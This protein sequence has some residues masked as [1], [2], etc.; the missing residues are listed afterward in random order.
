MKHMATSTGVLV[1]WEGLVL[2]ACEQRLRKLDIG[3]E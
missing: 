1:A 3:L 2:K